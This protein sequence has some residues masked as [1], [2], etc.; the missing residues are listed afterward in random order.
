MIRKLLLSDLVDPIT[1]SKMVD[2][3]ARLFLENHQSVYEDLGKLEWSSLWLS[4]LQAMQSVLDWVDAKIAD[5]EVQNGMKTG[6]YKWLNDLLR[7]SQENQ[8][9]DE[10]IDPALWKQTTKILYHQQAPAG[11][12]ASV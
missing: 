8:I 10:K 2:F 12:E 9:L 6:I 1:V 4:L 5:K 7:S 3:T 11:G